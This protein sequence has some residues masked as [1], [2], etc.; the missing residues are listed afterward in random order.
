[1]QEFVV[2][3][4]DDEAGE[5]EKIQSFCKQYFRKSGQKG[6]CAFFS[7][8]E[9]VLAYAG[10]R[11]HLL[12]LDVEMEEI[13]GLQVLRELEQSDL[14]WRVVFVTSHQETVFDSF[15]IKTLGFEKKPVCYDNIE[16][17]L[18]IAIREQ[19]KNRVI[20]CN[21]MNGIRL[22]ELE[23]LC[24]LEAQR[25]YVKFCTKNDELLVA[26]NLKTWEEKLSDAFLVRVHKTYLVN[27]MQVSMIGTNVKLKDGRQ[28]PIGR[29]YK[30]KVL[31]QYH[32]YIC[33]M[34]DGRM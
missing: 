16:K 23:D 32:K 11:M 12:F 24:Y 18:Q 2:G 8:G 31:D 15:G 17:W 3:I 33:Q 9:E 27:L 7:S 22:F 29:T 19:K 34:A 5:R 30:N 14:V 26:G 6:V 13:D 10:K 1:M 20:E 25:N 21:T 4:C 28:L